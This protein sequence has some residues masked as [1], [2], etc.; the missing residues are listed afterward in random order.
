MHNKLNLSFH[1][2]AHIDMLGMSRLTI[3]SPE[4]AW[5]VLENLDQARKEILGLKIAVHNSNS[6]IADR[7]LSFTF[8]D[9]ILLF[10]TSDQK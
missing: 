10:S 4:K 6:L 8:S 3:N 1:Y 7:V 9:T 2:V 5:S